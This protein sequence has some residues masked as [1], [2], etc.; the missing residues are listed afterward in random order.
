MTVGRP[1]SSVRTVL[2]GVPPTTSPV[3]SCKSCEPRRTPDCGVSHCG[4]LRASVESRRGGC[5][6]G[7]DPTLPVTKRTP[8]RDPGET[9]GRPTAESSRDRGPDRGGVFGPPTHNRPVTEDSPTWSS[10]S[11][12]GVPK[13]SHDTRVGSDPS[14]GPREEG[15]SQCLSGW[16]GHPNPTLSVLG[17]EPFRTMP[18]AE[19][20]SVVTQAGEALR[21][22]NTSLVLTSDDQSHVHLT[23]GHVR[24]S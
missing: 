14:V 8:G 21:H 7:G 20:T 5:V 15:V 23:H 6:S 9:Y 12:V 19:S 10:E 4:K 18:P 16:L 3:P 1:W 11:P 22:T 13:R 17:S 2:S 24:S